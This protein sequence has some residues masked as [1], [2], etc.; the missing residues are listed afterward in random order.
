MAL[1]VF[2]P[3][4]STSSY[5]AKPKGHRDNSLEDGRRSQQDRQQHHYT[6]V[7][8]NAPAPYES[9]HANATPLNKKK[10]E[11]KELNVAPVRRTNLTLTIKRLCSLTHPI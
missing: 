3:A 7:L 2:L 6:D 9:L 11:E 10:F 1:L 8:P 4:P 5:Q